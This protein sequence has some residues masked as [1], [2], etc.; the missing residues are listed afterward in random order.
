MGWGA[1]LDFC[2]DPNFCRFSLL[3]LPFFASPLWFSLGSFSR[4]GRILIVSVGGG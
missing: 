4:S 3:A 1:L 2:G